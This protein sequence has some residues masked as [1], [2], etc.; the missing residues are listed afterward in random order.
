MCF[1][2][3]EKKNNLFPINFIH[4]IHT[5]TSSIQ[6]QIQRISRS[7]TQFSAHPRDLQ[8]LLANRLFPKPLGKLENPTFRKTSLTTRP[9]ANHYTILSRLLLSKN[10]HTHSRTLNQKSSSS[11]S[12]SLKSPSCFWRAALTGSISRAQRRRKYLP[13]RARRYTAALSLSL[14]SSSLH[15]LINAGCAPAS[16]SSSP[17]PALFFRAHTLHFLQLAGAPLVFCPPPLTLELAVASRYPSWP[18]P[19][20]VTSAAGTGDGA[21]GKHIHTQI[22]VEKRDRHTRGWQRVGYLS[23]FFTLSLSHSITDVPTNE[24][25]REKSP[26]CL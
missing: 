21:G 5:F 9:G 2:T 13:V 10:T 22:Y 25:Q 3:Y 16:V 18:R 8:N 4:T 12:S 1:D 19:R 11:S 6:P 14:F 20:Y 23:M 15:F 7:F 24:C 26:A 17:R